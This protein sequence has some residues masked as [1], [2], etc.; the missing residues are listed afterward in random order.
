MEKNVRYFV[1]RKGH[2]QICNRTEV[3]DLKKK[4]VK[5]LLSGKSSC[6]T[7][8]AV[9]VAVVAVVVVMMENW[10]APNCLQG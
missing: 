5:T 9:I 2:W 6:G 8:Q 3:V 7:N 10:S 4:R 1:G